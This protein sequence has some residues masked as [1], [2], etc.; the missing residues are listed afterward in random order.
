MGQKDIAEKR[1]IDLEDV[2]ADIINAIVFEG[3]PVVDPNDLETETARKTYMTND[4]KLHEERDAAKWWKNQLFRIMLWGIENQTQTS[5]NMPLRV[6]GYDGASYRSQLLT[7]KKPVPVATLVL[8]YDTRTR[9]TGPKTLYEC[10]NIPNQIRSFVSDYRINIIELAWMEE[11]DIE[12][13]HGD[14]KIIIDTLVKFRKG[15]YDKISDQEIRHVDEV[16]K[17]MAVIRQDKRYEEVLAERAQNAAEVRN[18]CEVLDIMIKKGKEEGVFEGRLQICY[19]DYCRL[20]I[21]A[22]RAAEKLKLSSAEAFLDAC[23]ARGWTI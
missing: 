15:S 21:T 7:K 13:F 4:G 14:F 8:Y 11:K 2:F 18:M 12:K 23:K 19:E 16:L 10:F 20:E 3:S 9:W 22:E 6:I 1:I 5:D 17:L